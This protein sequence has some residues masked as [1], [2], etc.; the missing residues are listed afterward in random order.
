MLKSKPIRRKRSQNSYAGTGTSSYIHQM[1]Q[2]LES[3]PWLPALAAQRTIPRNA[4][5][6][7][8]GNAPR[9]QH[10]TQERRQGGRGERAQAT[11]GGRKTTHHAAREVADDDLEEARPPLL[12]HD[13]GA[14]T[15][16]PDRRTPPGTARPLAP[17]LLSSAGCWRGERRR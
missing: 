1:S 7:A 16:Q 14:G 4:D 12:V 17:N 10:N 11:A 6:E 13:Q 3:G 2:P 9:Q 15:T 5:K 8:E